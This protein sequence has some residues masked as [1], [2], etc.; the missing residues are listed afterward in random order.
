V[1]ILSK[2]RPCGTRASR[3]EQASVLVIVLWVAFGLVSVALYFGHSMSMELRVA[4]NRVASAEADQAIAGAVRYV[5]NILVTALYPGTLPD[6]QTYRREAVPVGDAMFWLL[7]RVDQEM[8]AEEPYFDLIDEGAKLNLNS[9]SAEMISYLPNML[10]ELASAIVDWR[11][12][13]SDPGTGGA[14]DD[15]YQRLNPAYTCKNGPYE[16]L[17]ELRMVYGMDLEYLY[18]EDAN[19]NGVLDL[20]EN[21][22][23]QSFPVD[24]RDGRLDLG[25]FEYF[26][27]LSSQ[28]TL[29]TNGSA[30]INVA[31][32]NQQELANLL[33][34]KFSSDRANQILAQFQTGGGGGG[35]GGGGRGAGGGGGGSGTTTLTPVGSV[36]E[37]YMKSGMTAQEFEQIEGD[38]IAGTNRTGL[39]NVNTAS[40]AVLACIPGVGYEYAPAMVAYRRS[41]R[42]R[43]LTPTLS[44][45]SEV[46]SST[47]AVQAGPYLTGQSYQFT[48]DIAAV[49]HYGRGYRRV[50][51]VFDTSDGRPRVIYRQDLSDLGWALGR[52]VRE[53]LMTLAK[54]RP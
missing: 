30:R 46:L 33:L 1:T 6:P 51:Y 16:S 24:N 7:G 35:G 40:E 13:D 21:D 48:A 19:L 28:P 14:E 44:W 8:S 5:S 50:R 26:T 42:N 52:K 36:L 9:A 49:G 20:N 12:T 15:I 38:I 25:L 53:S 10:P 31:G 41:S 17:F 22:G 47:N 39:V 3:A 34:E 23:E 29:R 18:G 37:F 43:L 54:N 32:T 11:D 2:G 27:V 4:D 45:V